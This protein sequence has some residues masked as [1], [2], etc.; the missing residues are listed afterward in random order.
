VG[1]P[2]PDVSI[3]FLWAGEPGGVCASGGEVGMGPPWG[4]GGMA[5]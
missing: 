4:H 2:A 1:Y 5:P 3:G